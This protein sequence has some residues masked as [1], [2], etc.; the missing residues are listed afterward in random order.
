MI[1]MVIPSPLILNNPETMVDVGMK[2]YICYLSVDS[3]C[4]QV[5]KFCS[6]FA[7]NVTCIRW[8]GQYWESLSNKDW[9]VVWN[10]FYFSIYWE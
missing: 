1:S 8:I 9:L 6:A 5:A 4:W 2:P 3:C 7:K 10:I